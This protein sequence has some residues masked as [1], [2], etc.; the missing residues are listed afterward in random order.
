MSQHIHGEIEKLKRRVLSLSGVVES[1]L[2]KA[3][4]AVLRNDTDLADEVIAADEGVDEMEVEI[5]E[6]C[7][8]I[9][10]L[11]QPVATDLRF[12]VAVLKLNNDLERVGDLAVNIAEQVQA[13]KT[14]DPTVRPHVLPTM[15][16]RVRDMFKQSLDALIN[17]DADAARAVGA[18]DDEVDDMHRGMF[19]YVVRAMKENPAHADEGE[20]GA[21]R[22]AHPFSFD[23]ALPRAHRRSRHQYRRGRHLHD[24]RRHRAAHWSPRRGRLGGGTTRR[25]FVRECA[26]SSC[27]FD[28]PRRRAPRSGVF[29]TVSARGRAR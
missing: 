20:P 5:E 6:E 16:D 13:V 22:G 28:S 12:V 27:P 26:S 7:L 15:I 4:A 11:Y 2:E 23:L 1:S 19:G 14:A 3:T 24:R 17:L 9:L 29:L 10:A 25:G 21:R 8:K 18:A